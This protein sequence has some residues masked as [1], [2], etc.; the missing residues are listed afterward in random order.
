M[1]KY[2]K[3]Y[4]K[5][6]ADYEVLEQSYDAFKDDVSDLIIALCTANVEEIM[7]FMA[8]I[9]YYYYKTPE[10]SDIMKTINEVN[11]CKENDDEA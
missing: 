1:G 7:N 8:T 10:F 9:L 6:K 3:K 5:L 2:K 4:Y 11:Q